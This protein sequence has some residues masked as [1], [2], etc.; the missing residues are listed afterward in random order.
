MSQVLGAS[1]RESSKVGPRKVETTEE[2]PTIVPCAVCTFRI[3]YFVI[4][5]LVCFLRKIIVPRS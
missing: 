1:S 3:V 4:A 2:L 5:G